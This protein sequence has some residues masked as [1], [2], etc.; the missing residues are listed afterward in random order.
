MADP[1]HAGKP[2]ETPQLE[3]RDGEIYNKWAVF[4]WTQRRIGEHYGISQERVSQ[5]IRAARDAEKGFDREAM[6]Q[7]S[8]AFLAD[9]QA[10]QMEL[11]E[12]LKAGAPIAVGKD[13]LPFKVIDDNPDSP[14]YGEEVYVRDYSGY[15]AA[16]K[17]ARATEA[18]RAKRFGLN[19]P[20]KIET[21][22]KIRYEITGVDP[23][24][25]T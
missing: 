9:V 13:G 10:R 17:E 11:A 24:A 22:Q 7:R 12:R 23:D 2:R 15:L 18:E 14:T 8:E 19:A 16:L 21:V 1:K 5:I 6:Q 20:D 25:L 4:M 3:G